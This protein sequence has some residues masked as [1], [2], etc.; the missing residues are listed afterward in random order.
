MHGMS[1]IILLFIDIDEL[2]RCILFKIL[3]LNILN[4]QVISIFVLLIFFFIY[5][6]VFVLCREENRRTRKLVKGR[7][8]MRTTNPAGPSFLSFDFYISFFLSFFLFQSSKS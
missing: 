3:H 4:L 7:E 6:V 5:F 2:Q 8:G 1:R